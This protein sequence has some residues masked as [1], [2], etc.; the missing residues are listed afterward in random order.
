VRALGLLGFTLV[1]TACA[2][3]GALE[4]ELTLPPHDG[5]TP[6][7]A[8]VQFESDD[9]PFEN[10]WRASTDYPG[11]EL[12]STAQAVR[13]SVLSESPE[14]VVQVKVRFCRTPTCTEDD[15]VSTPAVWYR[16]ERS[17]YV[18]VRTWWRPV[19]QALPAGPPSAP[20]DIDKCQIEGCIQGGTPGSSFCRLSGEH[21]CEG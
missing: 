21:F 11:V 2:R 4:V 14:T 13:Y 20:I 17:L 12:T 18:G 15:P 3:N 5:P 19:I 9:Q 1:A 10:D 16:L 6:P 8:F 7:Y